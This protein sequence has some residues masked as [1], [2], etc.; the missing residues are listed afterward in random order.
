MVGN[1]SGGDGGRR[2]GNRG[3]SRF[4]ID[5]QHDQLRIHGGRVDDTIQID[6]SKHGPHRVLVSAEVRT[7]VGR[8]RHPHTPQGHA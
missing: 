7:K 8:V 5:D 6:A 1:Q 3:S 2:G 4:T